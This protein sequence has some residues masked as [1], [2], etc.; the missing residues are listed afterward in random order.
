[1]NNPILDARGLMKSFP[2]GER[3]IEVLRGLDLAVAPGE[4]ISIRTIAVL[5]VLA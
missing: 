5:L 3:R 4:S 2:S 1:M